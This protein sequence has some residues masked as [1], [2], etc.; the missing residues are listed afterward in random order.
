MLVYRTFEDLNIFLTKQAD[1]GFSVGLVPT[2]GALHEGH[3]SLIRDSIAKA[4][5]TICS[6]FVNPTQFNQIEDLEKYP[7]NENR[8]LNLLRNNSCDIVFIPAVEEVYPSNYKAAD[9]DL[10]GLDLMME[11]KHRPGHFDG[12]VQVLGRF[13]EQINPSYAFFG[14]KDYQQLVIIQHMVRVRGFD[15]KI[16]PCEI[17]REDSGLA[18]SSRNERLTDQEKEDAIQISEKLNWVC[19]NHLK[20]SVKELKDQII[21]FFHEVPNMELEY[22][23]IVN[24]YTL[25]PVQNVKD[26]ARAF[27]VVVINQVRL[28]DNIPLNVK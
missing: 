22:F 21:S 17:V 27:I 23:E 14:E 28:L 12:V 25:Q 1:L 7:R 16:V 2:M 6:I 18:M 10:V 20:Y 8:D 24:E 3:M 9:V 26:S 4:D 5:I 19:S 15:I 11:G 13:F